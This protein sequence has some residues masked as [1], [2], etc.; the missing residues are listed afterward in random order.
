MPQQITELLIDWNNGSPEAM[1][2][3]MPMVES[4]LR[5]IA[6]NYMRR[7][8]P[9]HTLQTSALVNEAYLKLVDQRQ[10]RWQNRSHFFALA[11]QLM[12]RILLDHARSQRRAK[13]G[14]DAI[15]LNLDDVAVLAPEKSAELVA[16]DDA[17]TRLAEFDPRKAK[18]VE[19]RFFGGLTVDEVAEALGIAPITVML[20]WRLAR[21]WLQR[22]MRGEADLVTDERSK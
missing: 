9:G 10:V 2:K 1:E 19:M 14:G 15:P 21:A 5:R 16:L 8:R 11:S 22:E 17:L 6:A 4:E 12:R 7:E 13:R 3:L 20:H 18:I